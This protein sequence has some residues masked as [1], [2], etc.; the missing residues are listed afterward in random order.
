M[1]NVFSSGYFS[2]FPLIAG[3]WAFIFAASID[4]NIVRLF[5]EAY[6]AKHQGQLKESR[7]AFWVGL[8]LACVTGAA[9][10]IEGLQQS[11]GLEWN[12]PILRFVIG[13]LIF[14]RVVLVVVLMAREGGKLGQIILTFLP[15]IAVQE[16]PAL[17]GIPDERMGD[18]EMVSAQKEEEKEPL[19]QE[20]IEARV[21]PQN[22]PISHQQKEHLDGS[23]SRRTM[24]IEE[25]VNLSGLTERKVKNL[26]QKRVLKVSSRN[27]NLV[28]MS[29]FEEWQKTN[30][31]PVKEAFSHEEIIA[32]SNGK[33]HG[34]GHT[35]PDLKDLAIV[36]KAEAE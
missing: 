30:E 21:E 29:S 20:E 1:T 31:T 33:T 6:I 15:E 10:L 23:T 13:L 28:L 35:H 32:E 9:L 4:V 25:V 8:G 27:K 17:S 2:Q 36:A 19:I 5:L 12:D 34:N 11:I 16:R 22:E 14:L 3:I 26:I 7:I 18:D 24:T